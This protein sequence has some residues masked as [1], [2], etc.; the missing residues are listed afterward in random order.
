MSTLK[1]ILFP[2]LVLQIIAL[3]EN[4][5]YS[6]DLMKCNSPN[7]LGLNSTEKCFSITSLLESTGSFK[8]KCCQVALIYNPL[9][10]F[11]ILYGDLWKKTV[12]DRYKLDLNST[13]N[14]MVNIF[15]L[16]KVCFVLIS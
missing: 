8:G 2:L 10:S 6:E 16:K 9:Y 15:G 13:E 7:Q 12:C 3:D 11:K 5:I 14:E 4:T 1:I